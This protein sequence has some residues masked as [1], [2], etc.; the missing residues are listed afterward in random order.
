MQMLSSPVLLGVTSHLVCLSSS[1]FFAVASSFRLAVFTTFQRKMIPFQ[2]EAKCPYF[3]D[4]AHFLPF[5]GQGS[6]AKRPFFPQ[7]KH[8]F[9]LTGPRPFLLCFRWHLHSLQTYSICFLAASEAFAFS[10]IASKGILL[11]SNNFFFSSISVNYSID[12]S[13]KRS[14]NAASKLQCL[15]CWRRRTRYLS[16]GSYSFGTVCLNTCRSNG[17]FSSARKW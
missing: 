7:M 11:V 1:S 5:A 3:K 10:R 15:A 4:F 13:R 2:Q 16:T 14:S 9:F 17:M 8:V 12:W 6:R